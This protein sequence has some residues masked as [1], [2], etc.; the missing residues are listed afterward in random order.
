MTNGEGQRLL[1]FLLVEDDD[2]HALIVE[3]NLRKENILSSFNRVRDG[4]EALAYLRKEDQF[5]EV[6]RP[7]M[8]LLDL[9][10][11]K[12]NGHEVLQ[13]VKEDDLLRAIPVVILTTSAA[14]SD[15][16]KAYKHHAN[17]YLVKPID[18]ACFRQMLQEL[19]L[20]WGIWNVSPNDLK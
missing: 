13:I 2:S 15:V 10:L 19:S 18:M 7:D 4:E 1:N 8:I 3:R 6:N 9:K 11:P 12:L 20:Y 14:D 16:K 17:S 5:K